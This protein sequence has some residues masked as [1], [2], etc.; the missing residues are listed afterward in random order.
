LGLITVPLGFLCDNYD[1]NTTVGILGC[2]V[3][4]LDCI[5]DHNKYGGYCGRVDKSV[6]V[7]GTPQET[8]QVC[9][10]ND[11]PPTDGSDFTDVAKTCKRTIVDATTGEF[12]LVLFRVCFY[13]L[14]L[15]LSC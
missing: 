13:L 14:R 15:K 2:T 4:A 1:A 12:S 9:I 10:C 8:G 3:C 7:E 11:L 6:A 5:Y